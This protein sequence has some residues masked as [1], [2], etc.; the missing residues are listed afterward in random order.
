MILSVMVMPQTQKS[1]QARHL[2]IMNA[3]TVDPKTLR[4]VRA[5]MA[6][7]VGQ[8][9]AHRAILFGSRARGT[10]H[11]ESDADVAVLLKGEKGQFIKTK[12]RSMTL[13]MT[14][15]LPPASAS[16]R[17]RCGTR[18]GRI[19][20]SIPIPGCCRTSRARALRCERA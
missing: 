2:T 4:A 10:A 8:Y 6:G 13:P 18:N 7:V 15:C 12:W 5:F 1:E 19:R 3:S 17:Y 11:D 16:S 14:F 9:P 20:S